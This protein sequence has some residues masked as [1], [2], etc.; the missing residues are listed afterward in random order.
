MKKLLV[1]PC[2]NPGNTVLLTE[3]L[4]TETIRDLHR[5]NPSM[6][7]TDVPST[8][9]ELG[10]NNP[11]LTP[12]K[13]DE[14]EVMRTIEIHNPLIHYRNDAPYY[15]IE[16]NAPFLEQPTSVIEF[17]E[18]FHFSDSGKSWMSRYQPMYVN[19]RKNQDCKTFTSFRFAQFLS[20]RLIPITNRNPLIPDQESSQ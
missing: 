5:V 20:V 18:Y 4:L 17:K 16:D 3:T 11:Y 1:R 2:L 9:V 10:E 13:V 19:D 15:F 6:S 14:P 7:L 12:L 8:A